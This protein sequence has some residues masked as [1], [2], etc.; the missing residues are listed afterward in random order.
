VKA[1]AFRTGWTDS[2][3]AAATYTKQSKVAT[4]ALSPA[5][6]TTFTDTLKVT[7]SVSTPS[8][9]IRHTTNGTDP[10]GSSPV[11]PSGGITLTGTTTVKARAFRTGWTDSDT[12][13]G[14]Y[15]KALFGDGVYMDQAV[16]GVRSLTDRVYDQSSMTLEEYLSKIAASGIVEIYPNYGRTLRGGNGRLVP[17]GRWPFSQLVTE[18]NCLHMRSL[19]LIPYIG[20]APLLTPTYPNGEVDV[21]RS[22]VRDN[23]VASVQELLMNNPEM[24]GLVLDLEPWPDPGWWQWDPLPPKNYA[25]VHNA[26]LDIVR[27]ISLLPEMSNRVLFLYVNAIK[28]GWLPNL[29]NEWQW[30]LQTFDSV[31]GSG[32]ADKYMFA[33]TYENDPTVVESQ[34][35]LLLETPHLGAAQVSTGLRIDIDPKTLIDYRPKFPAALDA[36]R[37]IRHPNS[38]GVSLWLDHEGNHLWLSDQVLGVMNRR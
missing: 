1:R 25:D 4:P 26:L 17:T 16:A 35:H 36:A 12:V 11:F 9:T 37:L 34:V 38:G 32:V 27:R 19:M 22:S 3:V 33:G 18:F 14:C 29:T 30:S 6:G 21:R 28:P 8:A 23:Y 20:L 2:D 13:A 24:V 15:T 10:T 31:A 7:A 5:S